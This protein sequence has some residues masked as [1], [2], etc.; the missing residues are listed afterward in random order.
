MMI[1]Q[2]LIPLVLFTLTVL[3]SACGTAP[4]VP[5]DHFFR[6]SPVHVAALDGSPRTEALTIHAIRAE[7][8]YAERAMVFTDEHNPRQ[9]RQYHYHLWLYPPSQL[10]QDHLTS[11]LAESIEIAPAGQAKL[12]LQGRILRFDRILGAKQ[13]YAAVTLELQ[14]LDNGRPVLSKTYEAVQPTLEDS[15]PAFI[16]AMERVLASIYGDF[17]LDL[18]ELRA[19]AKPGEELGSPK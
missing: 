13:N 11:S 8:L 14:V 4:P 9:L 18:G 2:P 17:L 3:L 16:E 19:G 5:S 7:S 15:F 1:R 12:A 6:L 10:V